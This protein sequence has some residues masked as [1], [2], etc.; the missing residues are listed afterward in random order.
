MQAAQAYVQVHSSCVRARE[1]QFKYDKYYQPIDAWRSRRRRRAASAE[2]GERASKPISA[3]SIEMRSWSGGG[4]VSA[5]KRARAT[6]RGWAAGDSTESAGDGAGSGSAARRAC[7]APTGERH[8]RSGS[9]PPTA[10]ALAARTP[11]R[12]PRSSPPARRG[13]RPR[14]RRRRRARRRGPPPRR[15]G[16]RRRGAAARA[17]P[18]PGRA[19]AP[20]RRPTGTAGA[21]GRPSPPRS[22]PSLAPRRR[23]AERF[24][25][26]RLAALLLPRDRRLAVGEA[27][28]E[29]VA[30][31]DD[32]ARATTRRRCSR[33]RAPS[34]PTSGA[35]GRG[36]R[37]AAAQ[38]GVE[39]AARRAAPPRRRA[40]AAAARAS[41]TPARRCR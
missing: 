11:R 39:R 36:G 22:S 25:Q 16:A 1:S 31:G 35:R 15:R 18:R 33:A 5:V 12:G 32:A 3:S 30:V 10:S 23:V 28:R 21:F 27:L 40:P 4:S 26:Q 34:A 2:S 13:A 20:P 41:P 37:R 14:R 7:W 29:L 38:R 6:E 8:R 17:P 9:P 19:A 24:E